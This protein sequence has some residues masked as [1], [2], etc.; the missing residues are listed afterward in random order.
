MLELLSSLYQHWIQ[1]N[2]KELFCAKDLVTPLKN[3]LLG[4]P[5]SS[6]QVSPHLC[7]EHTLVLTQQLH[8]QCKYS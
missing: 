6:V 1:K 3:Q 7:N 8:T 4:G 5:R 2:L